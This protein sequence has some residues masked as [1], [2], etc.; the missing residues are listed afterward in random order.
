MLLMIF[1]TEH[2]SWTENLA[3]KHTEVMIAEGAEIIDI[4]ANQLVL[5]LLPVPAE[6]QEQRIIPYSVFKR[7]II[8]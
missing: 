8:P 1:R 6:I 3:I 5:V 4:G 7:K 2:N